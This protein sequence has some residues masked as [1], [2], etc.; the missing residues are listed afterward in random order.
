MRVLVSGSTGLVGSRLVTT[1]RDHQDEVSRLVRGARRGV[2]ASGTDDVYWDPVAGEIEHE[3]LEQLHAVIHLAGEGIA[4]R[5]WS[6]RQ[7]ARIRDSRVLGT[8]LLCQSLA[9]CNLKPDVLVC[10][11]AIGFYGD[12]GDEL[13]NESSVSGHG[14]LAELC[15]EWESATSFARDTG[16]RVVNLRIG[17]V[18]S[19]DGGAL[20]KMLLPFQL[21]VGGI[22]G[23]GRQFM[24]WIAIDDL[25]EIIR[26]VMQTDAIEGPTNATA[27]HPVTNYEFTK[28]LGR[29][30]RRPTVFPMPG[31]AARLAFGEMANELLLGG[32][33][34]E[35]RRLLSTGFQF[36]FADLEPALRHV[37]AR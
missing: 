35:P 15:G 34:V 29:V 3:R 31:F 22:L 37:L 18:L 2:T 1:L 5:R 24:S 11:S 17:V 12:R 16:I 4:N 7:K 13:L 36:R 23:S 14:F 8:S 19:R 32:A 27:P 26:H 6:A 10:A 9:A 21:G 20:A 28:T 25:V 30:L 33:R